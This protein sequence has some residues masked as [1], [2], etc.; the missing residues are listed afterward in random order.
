MAPLQKLVICHTILLNNILRH[1]YPFWVQ[2]IVP[3][4]IGIH[5]THLH[6]IVK[7]LE[8][9]LPDTKGVTIYAQ[10]LIVPIWYY[11]SIITLHVSCG[12]PC[13]QHVI[14]HMTLIPQ[15]WD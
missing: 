12:T 13:K 10:I 3:H 9:P 7:S 11:S 5:E 15:K 14:H 1:W 4:V 2:H 8:A 6:K